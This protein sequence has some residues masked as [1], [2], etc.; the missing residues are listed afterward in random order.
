MPN[1]TKQSRIDGMIWGQMIGDAM[2]MG[3]HWIY[4]L[5][6]L[7]AFYPDLKGFEAPRPGHY[8]EGKQPGDFT[9]YGEAALI[10]LESIAE[11]GGLDTTDYGRRF[12]AH[13]GS[14]EYAGYLDSATRGTLE[15]VRLDSNK[16]PLPD[17][18]F[19]AGADDDQLATA[20]SLAPVV[21]RY[22]GAPDLGK[23]VA[24][25]TRVRQNHPRSIAYMQIHAQILEELL[26]GTDL[27]SAVHRVQETAA[28]DPEFG[29]ELTVRFREAFERKHLTTTE[30]TAQLG[31]SCPLKNS[32][33]SA[34]VAA[35]QTPD[36]FAGTLLRILAAGGD[37]A[38]R[39]A[40]TGAWLGA[41]LGLEAIPESLRA[42]LRHQDRVQAAVLSLSR[43]TGS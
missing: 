35:L 32:F 18:D 37:N 1:P 5:S 21:A 28:K 16:E 38:G 4:N 40:M 14:V 22:H 6:D 20:T 13:F 25:V 24:R 30:A 9:H 19:Q 36:E 17:F 2:C 23:Q 11:R 7:Q 15:K 10:L 8:H 34:L 42:K 3:T 31:Q 41:H 33:P 26:S 43:Q 39:A 29:P 12:V 27:H